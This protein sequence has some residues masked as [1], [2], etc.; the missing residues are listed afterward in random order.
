VLSGIN[1]GGN[2]GVDTLYSGTVGAAMEGAMHGY[3]AMAISCHGMGR[4]RQNLRYD[5]AG[6]VVR[7]ILEKM[8]LHELAHLGVFNVNVPSIPL[9][10]VKG[11][12]VASLGRRIY[13]E[14]MHEGIDPRGRPYYWI[15]AGG[16]MFEDIPSSDCVM[17]D[18]GY[19]T[20]TAL[21]PS[22]IDDSANHVVA[23]LINEAFPGGSF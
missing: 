19:V 7:T 10:D 21:K 20:I 23:T 22:L 3:P 4:E 18:Q 9:A 1:R 11:I 16:E 8:K 17:I 6:A 2:L 14:E 12:V 15:G 5:T 13:E